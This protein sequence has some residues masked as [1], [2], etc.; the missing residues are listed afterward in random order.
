MPKT[1]YFVRHGQSD[2]NAEGRVQGQWESVLT[3]LGIAQAQANG[4]ALAKLGV[5]KIYASPLKRTR[6]TAAAIADA[7]GN[8]VTFDARLKEWD[9]GDWSGHLYE[10][11]RARWPEE[12]AAWRQDMWHYRPPGCENFVDLFNRGGAFLKT[13]L[14]EP[15]DQKIAVVSHGFIMRAMIAYL[16]NLSPEDALRIAT[17]NDV[18]FRF[19][20][21][22][23]AWAP[24]RFQGGVQPESGLYSDEAPQSVA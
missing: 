3:D 1:L 12:W 5:T 11:V 21:K 15:P 2:W 10:D 7:T 17:E 14:G 19:T 22:T 4:A 16:I 6:Q 23:D 8:A 13:V 20:K 18:F 24:E 9:S